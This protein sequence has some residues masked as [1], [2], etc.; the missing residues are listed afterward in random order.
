MKISE[1]KTTAD[2]V[3]LDAKVISKGEPRQVNTRMGPTQVADCT[4]EDDSGTIT[5]TLWGDQIDKVKEGDMVRIEKG[6]IKEWNGQLQLNI[7]KFGKL[8]VLEQ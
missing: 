1:I 8:T 7:G 4:L 2:K 5:L 6:Y 3:D